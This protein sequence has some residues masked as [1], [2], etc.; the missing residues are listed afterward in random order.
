M[1][2]KVVHERW[3]WLIVLCNFLIY[4]SVKISLVF[5]SKVDVV[6]LGSRPFTKSN[7]LK[8]RR[9]LII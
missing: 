5:V 6:I 2:Y 4:F 3:K 8:N 7:F 1:L 9:S